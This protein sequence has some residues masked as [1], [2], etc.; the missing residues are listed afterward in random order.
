MPETEI[1]PVTRAVISTTSSWFMG[2]VFQVGLQG[3]VKPAGTMGGR[4]GVATIILR[5][6]VRNGSNA[7][8][9]SLI[10]MP[11]FTLKADIDPQLMRGSIG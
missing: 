11:A 8:K 3:T 7:E 10:L 5:R 6:Q 9:R 1:T 2:Y 4:R